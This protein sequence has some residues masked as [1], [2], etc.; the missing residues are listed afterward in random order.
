MNKDILENSISKAL[1][2]G[3]AG[4]MAMTVNVISMTWLRTIVNYQYRNSGTFNNTIKIL[5]KE[6]GIPRFYKGISFAL[7]I[8]PL[9]RFGDTSTNTF[10]NSALKDTNLKLG[11]L[12]IG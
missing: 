2:G 4:F 1:M 5:Y 10:V 11:R 7:L 12:G 8:A 6:G 3:K 9:S